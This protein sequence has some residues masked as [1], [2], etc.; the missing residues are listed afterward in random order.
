MNTLFYKTRWISS[1]YLIRRNIFCY[2]TSCTY[3]GSLSNGYRITYNNIKSYKDIIFYMN[4]TQSKDSPF[5][6]WI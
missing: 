2:Y 4:F 6:V 1:P 5:F 3:N